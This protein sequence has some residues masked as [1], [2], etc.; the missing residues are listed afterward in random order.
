MHFNLA[1][2]N[3]QLLSIRVSPIRSP[4]ERFLT[5][6]Q[7]LP[8]VQSYTNM[9]R[10]VALYSLIVTLA[11]RN[12]HVRTKMSIS[13]GTLISSRRTVEVKVFHTSTLVEAN[14]KCVKL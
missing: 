5:V 11:V 7:T 3:C 4:W 13:C 12:T 1:I 10:N 6:T 8:C 2:V 9:L 14:L